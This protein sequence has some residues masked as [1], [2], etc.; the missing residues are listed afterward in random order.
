MPP[1]KALRGCEAENWDWIVFCLLLT[2]G[3]DQ[4]ERPQALRQRTTSPQRSRKLQQYMEKTWRPNVTL[5]NVHDIATSD[6]QRHGPNIG[7]AVFQIGEN[8]HAEHAFDESS[9]PHQL[10]DYFV[11]F[12][13]GAIRL[14]KATK[15]RFAAEFIEGDITNVLEQLHHGCIAD[16]ESSGLR[17]PSCQQYPISHARLAHDECANLKQGLRGWY[18]VQI[19]IGRAPA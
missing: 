18:V 2:L 8:L 7:M 3:L 14:M 4:D 12:S 15:K 13:D 10:Y 19:F 1:E 9:N 6:E 11:P 17:S 16:R 5:V